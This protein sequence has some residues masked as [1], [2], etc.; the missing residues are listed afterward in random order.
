MDPDENRSGPK[1]QYSLR[2]LITTTQP[3]SDREEVDVGELRRQGSPDGSARHLR[4]LVSSQTSDVGRD[5]DRNTVT[6][7]D[8]GDEEEVCSGDLAVFDGKFLTGTGLM[9]SCSGSEGQALE[10]DR[11]NAADFVP[12][13]QLNTSSL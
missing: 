5:A 7:L 11:L 1:H 8:Y 3:A 6:S 10:D 13:D 4:G 9:S 2:S 12:I